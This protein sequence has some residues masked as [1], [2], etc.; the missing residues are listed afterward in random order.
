MVCTL[1]GLLLGYL[2]T[3]EMDGNLWGADV[4]GRANA[5]WPVENKSPEVQFSFETVVNLPDSL[6]N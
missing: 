1:G 3:A 4:H 2:V 5:F 6:L